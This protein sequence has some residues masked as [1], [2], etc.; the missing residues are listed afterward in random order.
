MVRRGLSRLTPGQRKRQKTCNKFRS[1]LRYHALCP[2]NESPLDRLCP[3]TARRPIILSDERRIQ[4]SAIRLDDG[5]WF[6][7][8]ALLVRLL[9]DKK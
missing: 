5:T 9:R 7:P 3:N 2:Y 6:R 8:F 4:L 1:P